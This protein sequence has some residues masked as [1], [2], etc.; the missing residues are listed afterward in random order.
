MILRHWRHTEVFNY[1]LISRLFRSQ[2]PSAP[3]ESKED[4]IN[5]TDENV[6]SYK[7]SAMENCKE[8]DTDSK[9]FVLPGVL[10]QS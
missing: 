3:K 9:E 6:T 2:Q 7:K 8:S 5:N 4:S 1:Y 10:L